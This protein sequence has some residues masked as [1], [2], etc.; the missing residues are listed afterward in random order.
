MVCL[1][2]GVDVTPDLSAADE[3]GD[4]SAWGWCYRRPRTPT[5]IPPKPK[6]RMAK[7]TLRPRGPA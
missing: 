7:A 3:A 6:L 1:I 4:A 5:T 2:D